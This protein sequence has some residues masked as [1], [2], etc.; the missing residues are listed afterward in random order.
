MHLHTYVLYVCTYCSCYIVV[1]LYQTLVVPFGESYLDWNETY[2]SVFYMVAGA[3]V[4]GS[5]SLCGANV[6]RW[7]CLVH[8]YVQ[9]CTKWSELNVIQ[10][11]RL[12][13]PLLP[14][15][16]SAGRSVIGQ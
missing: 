14:S 6:R 15:A 4:R 1:F 10:L 13:S 2:I 12:F 7:L 16:F 5:S 9:T 11:C 3:E 8:L